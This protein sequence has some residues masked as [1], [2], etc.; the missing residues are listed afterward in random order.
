M[1]PVS[2]EDASD[3]Y[4]VIKDPIDFYTI[5]ERLNSN[6]Y[7]RPDIFDDDVMRVFANCKKYNDKDT[8]YW[9]L[10]NNLQEFITPYIKKLKDKFGN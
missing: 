8:I 9:L 2:V 6:Y 1:K 3:Y 7:N 4:D 10:A 5:G